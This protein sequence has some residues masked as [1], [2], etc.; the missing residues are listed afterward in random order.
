[1]S[2][3]LDPQSPLE[4]QSIPVEGLPNPAQAGNV[5]SA[6]LWF[7][8]LGAGLLAG[9]LAW[10]VG[11][12]LLGANKDRLTPKME[13][14][15]QLETKLALLAAKQE[16]ATLIFAGLGAC[17]GFTMGIAGGA[18]RKSASASA[19]AAVA[20]LILGGIFAGGVAW[21]LLPIYFSNQ[22]AQDDDLLL[23]MLIH[24]GIASAVGAAGGAAMGIGLGG[25]TG[26]TIV[27]GLAGAAGGAVLFEV[28]GALAFP[29]ARTA[30]PIS[31]A[32]ASRLMLLLFVTVC[33]AMG[34]VQATRPPAPKRLKNAP[35]P[36]DG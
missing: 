36:A 7:W 5:P 32:M 15:P 3:P 33:A 21:G 29:T 10:L 30:E 2:V 18:A 35:T 8:A 25:R 13:P 31:A 24:V 16:V 6:R 22:K 12:A 11:E 9:V 28:I 26:Q 23:P 1:M 14:F 4:P 20:G 17:F 27:G 34:A 19:K